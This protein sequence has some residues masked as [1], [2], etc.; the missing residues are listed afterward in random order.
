MSEDPE[1]LRSTGALLAKLM[2]TSSGDLHQF[3][4]DHFGGSD[5]ALKDLDAARAC[6][7]ALHR[8]LRSNNAKNW[9]FVMHA[10]MALSAIPPEPASKDGDEPKRAAPAAQPAPPHVPPPPPAQT[11]PP[12]AATP[13]PRMPPPSAPIPAPAIPADGGQKP[14]FEPSPLLGQTAPLNVRSPLRTLPFKAISEDVVVKRAAALEPHPE[15]G[16]TV[17]GGSAQGASLPFEGKPEGDFVTVA[18]VSLSLQQYAELAALRSREPGSWTQ[19]LGALGLADAKS[20]LALEAAWQ[21]RIATE[22]EIQR[23]WAELYLRT[24][25]GQKK[26]ST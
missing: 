25:G 2:L 5:I 24:V 26:F 7:L 8:A 17:S 20:F 14:S 1:S 9:N 19:R 22:P 6:L 10:A 21:N 13:P 16:S 11:P 12:S 15:L 4:L 3:R 23:R 18:D